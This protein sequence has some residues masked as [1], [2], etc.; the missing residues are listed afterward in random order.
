LA[1]SKKLKQV[2]E[3]LKTDVVTLDD[4]EFGHRKL[5]DAT[6]D[7][8]EDTPEEKALDR[9]ASCAVCV[10]FVFVNIAIRYDDTTHS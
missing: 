6:T 10:D 4:V 5:D 1:A 3:D 7:V 9:L 8:V 2:K